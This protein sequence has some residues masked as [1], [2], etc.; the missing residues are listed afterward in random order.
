MPSAKYCWDSCVFIALLTGEA[1]PDGEIDGMLEVVDLV[2]RHQA[3]I[4]TSA[5]VRT[6]VLEDNDDP[7]IRERL[8]YM[9]RRPS[10]VMIDVNAAI[11]AKAGALR[12]TCRAAGRSL[13]TPDAVFIATATLHGA[14]ALH[15]LDDQ[16]LGLSGLPEVDGL[17][18]SKPCGDQT[19]LSL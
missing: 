16:L 7:A 8:E 17:L 1:R 18:I 10:C 2:D 14:V 12:A 5:L 13:K 11:S 6:E 9:F 19:I 15:T 4:I 3:V